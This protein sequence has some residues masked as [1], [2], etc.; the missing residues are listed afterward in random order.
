MDE[1]PLQRL[2]RLEAQE[3]AAAEGGG[4]P[5]A[6]KAAVAGGLLLLLTKGKLLLGALKLGPLLGTFASMALFAAV[7]AR[8]YGA[9]LAIGLVLL[10]YLHELGHGAAAKALGL[11]VGAPIFIPF[12]GAF[13]ALKEQ[14]RSSWVETRVAVAGPAAGLL[15]AV[16]CLAWAGFSPERAG[17]LRALAHVTL[18]INLFNLLPAMG[19][20][21]DR[22]TE[23]LEF[24]HWLAAL[25]GLAVLLA[26][27][28]RPDGALNP[29]LLM[30]G[31]V[32]GVKAWGLRGARRPARLVDRL[33]AVGRRP[34]EAG[35]EESHR[36]AA[37]A[38]YLG[39][40]AALSLLGAW[41]EKGQPMP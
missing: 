25:A 18:A 8:L 41:V 12:L 35:V 1:T 6:G 21:G 40:S 15:G 36:L 5:M 22:A 39:L 19:L 28:R 7:Y 24:R 27:T 4:A 23:P 13:I 20:D 2:R 32:G 11:R 31:V 16:A 3:R 34:D 17:L 14:P 29:L 30:I 37:L 38:M 26:A 10:I 9:S 33:A